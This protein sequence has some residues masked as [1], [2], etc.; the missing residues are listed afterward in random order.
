MIV[1]LL[2]SIFFRWGNKSTESWVTCGRSQ[3]SGSSLQAK[4]R[5]LLSLSDFCSSQEHCHF[6][7]S[8]GLSTTC[9][10]STG[11][12][13]PLPEADSHEPEDSSL[14]LLSSALILFPIYLEEL[15]NFNKI[16]FNF[17]IKNLYK[18]NSQHSCLPF[19]SIHL[20]IHRNIE[21]D[22]FISQI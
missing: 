7:H 4:Y 16:K 14:Q 15:R 11:N 17:N 10:P 22:I 8:L 3:K 9:S 6:C 19:L 1:V 21:R 5:S 13:E 2:L 18:N 12:T 20:C